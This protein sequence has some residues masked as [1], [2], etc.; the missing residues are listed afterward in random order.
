MAQLVGDLEAEQRRLASLN[1]MN[2]LFVSGSLNW[3]S[4]PGTTR[5][6]LQTVRKHGM[7][8]YA[9]LHRGKEFGNYCNQLKD[10][11]CYDEGMWASICG[12]DI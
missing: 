7:K 8:V 11:G 5:D 1:G 10:W 12:V 9:V 3:P 4:V 6:V 2:L